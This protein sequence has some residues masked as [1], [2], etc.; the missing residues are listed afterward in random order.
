MV[1]YGRWSL[2]RISLQE[3]PSLSQGYKGLKQWKIIKLPVQQVAMVVYKR[4]SPMRGSFHRALNG[5]ILVFSIGGRLWEVVAH[6]RRSYM[7]VGL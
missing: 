5:K 3:V 6:E 1:A 7:G 4:G 2:S